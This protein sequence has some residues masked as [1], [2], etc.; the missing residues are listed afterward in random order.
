MLDNLLLSK[1]AAVEARFEELT[2]KLSDPEVLARPQSMQ[3]LAKEHSDLRELVDA[4]RQHRE[5]GKR[6]HAEPSH[7]VSKTQGRDLVSVVRELVG[8]TGGD[9]QLRSPKARIRGGPVG[10]RTE[11]SRRRPPT[12]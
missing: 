3:K 9:Q 6:H 1:L 10:R 4:L 7:A 12:A 2:G 8:S 11:P 5:L